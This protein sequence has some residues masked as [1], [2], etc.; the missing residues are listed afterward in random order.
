MSLRSDPHERMRQ[1][2]F[3]LL[4]DMLMGLSRSTCSGLEHA[5]TEFTTPHIE[6]WWRLSV[7][8][9]VSP[10]Y[11][12]VKGRSSITFLSSTNAANEAAA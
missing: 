7:H 10:I 12:K 4:Q 8:D 1:R 3:I 11:N 9:Y 2:R 6:R 5:T